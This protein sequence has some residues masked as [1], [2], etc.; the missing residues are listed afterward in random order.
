MTDVGTTR[1]I[2]SASLPTEWGEFRIY[3]F[4]REF[5]E[6][7]W[8]RTETAV[9]LTMGDLMSAPPLLRIHSQ[10]LTG[11][12]FG[13][14]RCDCGSQLKMA[15]AA[16]AREGAGILIY[17]K[18]EGRGIGLMP[19]LLAYQLQDSGCDTVEAN[20]RLGLKNDYRNYVLATEI[21]RIFGIAAVRLLSNNPEKATALARAGI[22]V[23]ERVPCEAEPSP[24][25]E[26]YLLTKK[27]KMG[28]LLTRVPPRRLRS[29][30]PVAFEKTKP[31]LGRT[32]VS[33]KYPFTDVE[34]AVAELRAG[35]MIVLVDDEDRENEGDLT[36]IAE[37]VTPEA[38]NF[39]AQHGR[40]LI[41]LSMTGE[42]LDYLRLGPMAPEN[43]SQFGTAFTVS[44]DALGRGVS[45]GI[46]A[47]D[48]AQTILAA[49]DPATRPSDLARPG[50]VF[51]LRARAGGVLVRGGQ[52]EASVDLAR[53][54][55]LAPAAVICE[56]MNPDG[57]MA[58][59]P[60]LT[61]FCKQHGLKMLTVAELVRYRMAHE[62]CI[63]RQSESLVHT[64][65]GNFRMV[66]YRS[67]F[68]EETH[69]AFVRSDVRKRADG[70]LVAMHGF[71]DLASVGAL[72]SLHHTP[73]DFSIETAGDKNILSFHLEPRE[74]SQNTGMRETQ[75]DT[76]LAAQILRDL[77]LRRIRLLTDDPREAA[78]LQAYDLEVVEQIVL[79]VSC[80]TA[81]ESLASA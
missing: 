30:A 36:V 37:K 45:T 73:D 66:A 32:P 46:S 65:L 49:I 78:A 4:E 1:Q 35:R 47:Y 33:T 11:D 19:K 38:I 9:A 77:Q 68:D 69:V 34:T 39:M 15:M 16:I 5:D 61:Q 76:G 55:G 12:I 22:A 41:C 64:A 79:P 21:L 24:F 31:A 25:A 17:E 26:P 10:C 48:R 43:T 63:H 3:G 59:V 53:I 28:H 2:A 7:G 72:I 75:L 44:I 29:L 62:T 54:A 8:L 70:V 57:T 74:A 42:R 81:P 58:R 67:S 23:V 14:L 51:P 27:E 80:E 40:G 50:H 13:S 71:C 56:V 6:G 18:Q 52:T 60:Q 20:E